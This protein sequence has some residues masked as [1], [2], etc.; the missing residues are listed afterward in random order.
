M[1]RAIILTYIW[2]DGY[3][4]PNLRSKDK[5][6]NLSKK[7]P[8]QLKDVPGWNF[9]GSSTKQAATER[10]DMLLKPVKIISDPTLPDTFLV[11]C[12]VN[13]PNGRP[14]DSNRRSLLHSFPKTNWFYLEPEFFLTQDGLPLGVKSKKLPKQGEF[15]CGVGTQIHPLTRKIL[16][17]ATRLCLKARL[18]IT[19]NNIEVAP[20][21]I[22]IQIGSKEGAADAGDSL[23]LAKYILIRQAEEYGITVNFHPKPWKSI[24]G[25][26]MHINFST[27]KMREVGGKQLFDRVI[28]SFEKN[29]EYLVSHCG[30]DNNL[31]MTGKHETA[32]INEFSSGVSDRGATIRIAPETAK[33]WKGRLE[34]RLPNPYG[35]PYLALFAV[36]KTLQDAKAS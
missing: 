34:Y 21:Q 2:L 28:G 12:E 1:K 7:G 3:N 27:H 18:S 5:I 29:H 4:P 32:N 20:G 13:S 30:F 19:G 31:R 16:L 10:S 24:N 14:H 8:P 11:M 9:D 36:E 26:G 22:E 17:E 23:C 6:H 15:Y 35:D 33:E 25:S